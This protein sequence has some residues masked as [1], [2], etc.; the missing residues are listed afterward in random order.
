MLSVGLHTTHCQ[1]ASIR[2]QLIVILYSHA[3]IPLFCLLTYESI[4]KEF[5]SRYLNDTLIFT[6]IIHLYCESWTVNYCNNWNITKLPGKHIFNLLLLSAKEKC[7]SDYSSFYSCTYRTSKYNCAAMTSC[8]H[9]FQIVRS[10]PS[11]RCI[12]FDVVYAVYV[13]WQV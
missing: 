10:R 5:M 4:V 13:T 9:C 1:T 3:Y 6:G 11:L 12:I 2:V 7:L 8:Y